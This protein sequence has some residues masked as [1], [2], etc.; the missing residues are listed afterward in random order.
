MDLSD[1]DVREQVVEW[2]NEV[3]DEHLTVKQ[4][5]ERLKGTSGDQ[6]DIKHKVTRDI[7]RI[8]SM[9]ERRRAE[10]SDKDRMI[11]R[12]FLS[13]LIKELN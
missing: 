11:F 12:Q 13:Q 1:D 9:V 7:S 5:R 4:L 8:R 3:E 6:D 2:V 10:W